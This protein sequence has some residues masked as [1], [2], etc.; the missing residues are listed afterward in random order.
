MAPR[1]GFRRPARRLI[2]AAQE[3][4]Q[5][6]RR[7]GLKPSRVPIPA[8]IARNPG[9]RSPGRSAPLQLRRTRP[10]MRALDVDRD[11]RPPP[12]PPVARAPSIHPLRRR[13]Q[14]APKHPFERATPRRRLR[15]PCSQAAQP[16]RR[17]RHARVRPGAPG[18][19]RLR[20]RPRRRRRAA[21]MAPC[22]GSRRS[23]PPPHRRRAEPDAEAARDRRDRSSVHPS[24]RSPAFR[25]RTWLDTSS[26]S[27][28]AP[29]S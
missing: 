9:C 27:R 11:V 26:N 22:R 20:H 28:R 14:P 19:R 10:I 12:R 15:V 5:R 7:W 21:P 18:H 25:T 13:L 23:S 6:N 8:S 17:R 29:E 3:W 16:M 24:R 1:P 2:H 4:S